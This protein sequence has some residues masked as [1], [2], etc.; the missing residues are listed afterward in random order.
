MKRVYFAAFSLFLLGACAAFVDQDSTADQATDASALGGVYDA[1]GVFT[2]YCSADP[3]PVI[4]T[5]EGFPIIDDQACIPEPEVLGE[6]VGNTFR[7]FPTCADDE[8][9]TGYYCTKNGSTTIPNGEKP[10]TCGE[11]YTG[12]WPSCVE[13]RLST[14]ANSCTDAGGTYKENAQQCQSPTGNEWG[15]TS[16]GDHQCPDDFWELGTGGSSKHCIPK[17]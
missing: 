14:A 16:D 9:R 10:E 2:A 13:I 12:T 3:A 7:E 4:F 15:W 11:G 5:K 1:N 8:R 6:F 17:T